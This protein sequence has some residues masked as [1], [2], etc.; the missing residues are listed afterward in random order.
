MQD[1]RK[2]T[3][4]KLNFLIKDI[5]IAMLTTCDDGVLR[6]RPMQTQ[7]AEFDGSEVWFFTSKQTHK[8]E[9]IEK[10]NRV[11]V[12][13]AN[14]E[15]NSFVSLSGTAKLIDDR[16]KIE[17]LWS[18][19]FLAWFP[20]GLEDPNIIL[21]KVSVEHAEYWDATS[22]TLVEALGLLKSM[23][24]GERANGGDHVMLSL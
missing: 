1:N 13:Y 19:A 9:E 12:S 20:K 5:K 8:A 17:E 15:D 3:I 7:E 21:L 16:E 10:D 14:P 6:S 23:V 18:P 11:C 2:E 22:S 4:E 24:T